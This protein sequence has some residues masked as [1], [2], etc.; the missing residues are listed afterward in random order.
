MN[1]YTYQNVKLLF[2]AFNFSHIS[3]HHAGLC[4]FLLSCR[5][6]VAR[7]PAEGQASSSINRKKQLKVKYAHENSLYVMLIWF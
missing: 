1:K 4:D 6:A 3:S 7:Q 2:S 5:P